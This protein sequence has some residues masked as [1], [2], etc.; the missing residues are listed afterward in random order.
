MCN[1]FT[2]RVNSAL[3]P[4]K[5]RRIV[6]VPLPLANQRHNDEDQADGRSPRK[7]PGQLLV[8]LHTRSTDKILLPFVRRSA[9]RWRE[10][11]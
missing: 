4:P 5:L 10:V 7:T 11:N 3:Q 1:N 8:R 6:G 9:M 2:V